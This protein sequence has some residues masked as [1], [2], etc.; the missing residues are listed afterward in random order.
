MNT[1]S[2]ITD[3]LFLRKFTEH[4]IEPLFYILS[5]SQANRFLPWFTV[6]SL[7][8][9]R[10]FYLDRY[11]SVYLRPYGYAYAICLQSD[12]IPIGYINVAMNDS[13]DLGYGLRT[14]FWHNGIVT[15]AAMAV[16][17]QLKQ[18]GIP[19]ITATHDRNN[20]RSG[21]VMRN[22]GMSYQYTYGELWQPK[23]IMVTFR[24]YQLNLDGNQQRVYRKYWNTSFVHF[25]E[26]NL[27]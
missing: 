1:P 14:E 9:T 5:D 11:Y 19:Y 21:G 8:E 25:I 2:L 27:N 20:P 22:I 12:N 7:A 10:R 15:E 3:R 13:F 23:N 4:D 17:A 26:P 18:D 24:L 16:L 6:K